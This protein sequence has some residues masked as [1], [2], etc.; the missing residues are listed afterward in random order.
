MTKKRK[1]EIPIPEMG[2]MLTLQN[3]MCTGCG[4]GPW[5][6][7]EAE[8]VKILQTQVVQCYQSEYSWGTSINKFTIYHK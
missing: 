1:V 7:P 8:I 6:L 4:K 5:W 3:Q 2:L